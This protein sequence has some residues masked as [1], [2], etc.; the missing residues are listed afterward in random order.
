MKSKLMPRLFFL[1]GP[2]KEPDNKSQ[3]REDEDDNDPEHLDTG[4][5]PALG[6]LND[7][8]DISDED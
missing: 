8:P 4:R 3:N 6:Y 7:G 1:A 2:S 5:G